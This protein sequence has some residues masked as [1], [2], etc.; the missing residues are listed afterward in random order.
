MTRTTVIVGSSVG[1]VRTAQALHAT[2]YDG[3]VIL[4]GEEQ[5][6]PYDR[7]PLSKRFLLGEVS[8]EEICL[9]DRDQAAAADIELLLG[10]HATCVD[11]A[12]K[13]IE[14]R[15]HGP[16]TFDTLVIATGVSAL[17]SPWG[18]RR[19]A[20]TLRTRQDA[21]ALRAAIDAGGRLAVV[22]G[23]FIGAEVAAAARG[24]GLDVTI[25]D[26]L[27]GVLSRVVGTTLAERFTALHRER[28]VHTLFGRT[29]EQISGECGEFEL[30]LSDGSTVAADA[31]TVGIGTRPNDEWLRSSGLTLDNGVW[32]DQFCRADGRPDVFA[33]GD[34]ARWYHPGLRR[35]VRVEH[36]TNAVSQAGCVANN[37]AHPENLTS[38]H[39]VQYVWSDQY[40]WRI[41]VIGETTGPL[42]DLVEGGRAGQFVGLYES[43]DGR[44]DGA[45][46]A[47]WPRAM[48]Q[49]RRRIED[50]R[51]TGELRRSLTDQPARP[52]DIRSEVSAC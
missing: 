32:C 51:G 40:D 50:G 46:V 19:G 3:R 31:V 27:P 16:L 44:L 28:G 39:P 21:L 8:A 22:G 52:A 45:V 25:I 33:V 1:G 15:D 29:V 7:P 6:L 11:L 49:C 2:G 13:V 37:I 23:G 12:G 42:S 18:E 20:H 41:S 48:V 5:D 26:P 30:H 14:V 47:N 36:W 24:R 9:L 34:I 17:P 4:I 10:H 38:Y 35:R 43:P